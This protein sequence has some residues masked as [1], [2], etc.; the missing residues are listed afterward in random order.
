MINRRTFISILAACVATIGFSQGALA[1]EKK[2]FTMDSLPAGSGPGQFS[3]AFS[4]VVQKHLPYEIQIS[5]GKPATKSAVDAARG[6]VDFFLSAA[7]INHY[8]QTQS[9]MFAKVKNAKEMNAKLR[10]I[11]NYPIGPF[12]VVVYEESGITSMSQLKG[13]KVFLGPPAG[14]A[15]KVAMQFI[16][17]AT[18]L[19][20]GD[21]FEVM[22]Y[23]W[24]TAETAFL[25]KQMDAYMIPTTLPSPVIQ[26]FALVSK[27]R[28]LSIPDDAWDNEIMKK[29]MAVPGRTLVT[30][31]TGS[32]ENQT[33]TEDVSTVT[34][35]VGLGVGSHVNED[36]VYRM[37]KAFWENI[38]EIH[39]TA[40]WMKV[41]SKESVFTEANLPLHAG[42][43]RY[44][45]EIGW[46]VPENLI[47]PEAQ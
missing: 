37:T 20:P 11:M 9:A 46:D 44:Y 2:F 4:Q 47:P 10:F 3:I 18:G 35:W 23:D 16:E 19:K 28:L 27:V 15:T 13:K 39:Q 26:Q 6:Q 33:N 41:F 30:I 5:I 7:G 31:P 8:M 32:Y 36:D 42:A 45:R 29:M 1:Q 25:D 21:D 22:R 34:G 24:Q 12:H 38:G 43:Y 14:A 17:G 40:P